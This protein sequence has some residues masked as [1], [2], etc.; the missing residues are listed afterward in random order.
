M[1][2]ATGLVRERAGDEGLARAGGAGDEHVLVL[3]DPAAGGEL[4]DLGAI[5]LAAGGVVEVL[6]AGLGEAQLGLAQIAHQA[7]VLAPQPLG[8]DQQR[9][10]LIE[11][12]PGDVGLAA[13]LLP[14][15]SMPCSR[16]AWSF[17]V[18]GSFSIAVVL[19]SVSVVG[20]VSGSSPCRGCA[21]GR[22]R[23]CVGRALSVRAG[24]RSRPCLRIDSTCL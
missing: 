4:A 3:G 6:Q 1:A 11:A 17:S 20:A 15:G 9:E 12:E 10:A 13:L 2:V 5:E 16:S 21:R 24:S 7:L 23:A 19:L 14:G 8:L 22:R 18:V